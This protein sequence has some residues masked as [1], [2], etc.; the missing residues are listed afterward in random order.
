MLKSTQF[1]ALNSQI[2]NIIDTSVSL[3]DA[4]LENFKQAT[5]MQCATAHTIITESAN[6]AKSICTANSATEVA[7]CMQQFAANCTETTLEQGK[8]FLNALNTSKALY[9]EAATASLKDAQDILLKSVDQF[10]A[11]NPTLAKVA[12]ESLQTMISTTN[13][14]ADTAAKVSAQVA[15]VANKNI[16]AASKATLNT[17]KKATAK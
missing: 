10:A 1:S 2:N 8:E 5:L 17:V 13:Q 4:S 11:T 16:E 9:S 7:K 15:E 14:A 12:S 6:T 3:L